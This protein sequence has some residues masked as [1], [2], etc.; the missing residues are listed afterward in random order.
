MTSTTT[1]AGKSQRFRTFGTAFFGILTIIGVLAS[2]LAVWS[3]EVLFKPDSLAN[4]VEQ[5]L[6]EPAVTDAMATYLSKEIAQ[7]IPLD[8]AIGEKLP[9]SLSIL[10]PIL[11]GAERALVRSVV[12]RVL[13]LDAT[14]DLITAAARKA[15]PVLVR[16]IKGESAIKGVAIKDNKVSVNLLP[17]LGVA[18]G[19]LQKSGF[20]TQ[21]TLPDLSRDGDPT[22]QIAALEKSTGRSLPADF[23][24]LTVIEGDPVANTSAWV[25]QA[26]TAVSAFQQAVDIIVVL[27]VVALVFTML[28]AQRRRRTGLILLLSMAGAM[29]VARAV[30][31]AVVNNLPQLAT[32]PGARAAIQAMVTTFSSTLLTSVTI[33]LVGGLVL[34]GA[35]AVIKRLAPGGPPPPVVAKTAP[36]TWPAVIEAHRDIIALVA[37]A[38]AVGLITLVGFSPISLVLAVALGGAGGAVLARTHADQPPSETP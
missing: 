27:T 14:Q 28:L 8:T 30:I 34:A 32:D 2:V 19:S 4:A 11:V 24:Q 23:G 1:T 31:F 38:A 29:A 10:S 6:L 3:Q 37:F 13:T 35:L 12:D 7:A 17:V 15:Q 26:Q 16:V 25:S 5:A 33:L 21:V 36:T 20:L 9:P 22:Q 18:L